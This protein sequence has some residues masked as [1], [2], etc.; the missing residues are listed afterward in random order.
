MGAE[1]GIPPL[2]KEM[3]GED[4]PTG[5]ELA[6]RPV[7]TLQLALFCSSVAVHRA[8]RSVGF[9]PDQVLGVSFGEIAALT[10]AGVFTLADGARIACLL[11]RQLAC[12][13][14]GM[15]LI[16]AGEDIARELLRAA[17]RADL[18]VACV[19]GPGETI[20]SGP[21]PGLWTL[22]EQAARRCVPASRLRLPFSSHHPALTGPADAF[23]AAIG[24]L[25]ARPARLP[26][27][28]AVHGGRYGPGDDL[29][30]GMANCLVRPVRMP[31]VVRQAASGGRVVFVEAGTG[32]ALTR[33]IRQILPPGVATAHAPLAD[34][35]FPW[36]PPGTGPAARPSR[37]TLWSH[38]DDHPH[39]ATR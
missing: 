10:A 39:H 31:P 33:N 7:G 16:G 25:A 34:A 30:R 23:A 32:Q 15:T 12:C 20:V 13:E 21:L 36:P 5:R 9:G 17:G 14:G 24:P 26:V 18:A 6:A 1:F 11:A 3:L 28:S 2:A 35:A 22:E 38:H 19:N 37:T 8:L 29:H 4:P 27:L